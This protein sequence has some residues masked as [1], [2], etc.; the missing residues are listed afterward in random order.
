MP[1][2]TV[3]RGRGFLVPVTASPPAAGVA[4]DF[5]FILAGLHLLEK[6]KSWK[7]CINSASSWLPL[8]H[9]KLSSFKTCVTFVIRFIPADYGRNLTVVVSIDTA[10]R[11]AG[12]APG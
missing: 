7:L 4:L 1:S 12:P 11:L 3:T 5:L 8:V 9:R 6:R 10:V 2:T